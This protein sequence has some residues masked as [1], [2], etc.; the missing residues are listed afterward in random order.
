MHS[1]YIL[2]R[3]KEGL[4]VVQETVGKSHSVKNLNFCPDVAF[5]LDSILPKNQEIQ[6]NITVNQQKDLIGINV[7]GLLY[8]GGYTRNNMFGLALDYR[9]FVSKL[10]HRLLEITSVHILMIPHTF[11]RTGGINDDLKASN[12]VYD[13]LDLKFKDRV[14]R[15]MRE[16]NQH[17]I[18]G[19]IGQ[20]RFFIGSRMHSCIAA[21]S[22]NI[23]TVGVAYSRKFIGVFESIGVDDL[24]IDAR[25]TNTDDALEIVINHYQDR[26]KYISCIRDNVEK[27]RN[28]IAATFDSMLF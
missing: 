19:T 2:T 21:L 13:T 24:V 4:S 18:K 17:E 16:Y 11:S 9:D 25:N 26:E 12:T 14:H 28:L 27:A 20:C 10:L 5:M 8:N 7:N 1:E 23:P 3:D 15:V 6:P 22:Q